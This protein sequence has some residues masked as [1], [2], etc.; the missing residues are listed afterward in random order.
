M[1]RQTTFTYI[2][3]IKQTHDYI[4]V[5]SFLLTKRFYEHLCIRGNSPVVV[6]SN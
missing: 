1:K 6:L 4:A 2:S 5:D 3:E